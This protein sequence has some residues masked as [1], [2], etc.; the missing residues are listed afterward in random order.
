MK[1]IIT[2]YSFELGVLLAIILAIII[3]LLVLYIQGY[4]IVIN[5]SSRY[6]IYLVI[7]ILTTSIIIKK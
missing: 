6:S 3:S 7:I 5:N 4:P 1:R 2:K